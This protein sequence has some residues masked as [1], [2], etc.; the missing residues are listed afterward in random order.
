MGFG[1]FDCK[2][3]TVCRI[4]QRLTFLIG[5]L[6]EADDEQRLIVVWFDAA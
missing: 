6:V 5:F 3:D 4:E 1:G 2:G